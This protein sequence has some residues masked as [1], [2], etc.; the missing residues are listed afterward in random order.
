M[1]LSPEI[2][3][4]GLSLALDWGADWL[5]P[6][7]PRLAERF[8]TLTPEE[9]DEINA[10][11]QQAMRAGHAWVASLA[12]K[13]GLNVRYSEWETEFLQHYPW[14]NQENLGRLFSQG[15]YYNLK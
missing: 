15:M 9:L 8:L 10:T 13:D 2:L 4:T 6:I 14:V 7:Q 11:C 12:K 5:T 3:N 1:T